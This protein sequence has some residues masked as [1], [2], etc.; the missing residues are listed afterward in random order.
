MS[1][2]TTELQDKIYSLCSELF[3]QM[4]KDNGT[5]RHEMIDFLVELGR[6]Y[7]CHVVDWHLRE[8][9]CRDMLGIQAMAETVAV[10]EEYKVFFPTDLDEI[11]DINQCLDY[12]DMN[13]TTVGEWAQ[14]QL[15]TRRTQ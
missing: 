14:K 1:D 5:A 9:W 4:E 8:E 10:H 13:P 7:E 3:D 15:N 12:L 2:K 6:Q 11:G